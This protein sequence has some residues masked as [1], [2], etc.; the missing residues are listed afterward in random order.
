MNLAG[1]G[2]YYQAD[3]T[4]IDLF[5]NVVVR[6]T[7]RIPNRDNLDSI[8]ITLR[9]SDGVDND[10]DKVSVEF[11]RTY[12]NIEKERQTRSTAAQQNISPT[13]SPSPAK[14]QGQQYGQVLHSLETSCDYTFSKTEQIFMAGLAQSLLHGCG[15]PQDQESRRTLQTF[16]TSSLI[17]AAIGGTDYSNP[18]IGKSVPNSMASHIAYAAGTKAY[19]QIGCSQ[20]GKL[21]S[22]GM[23]KYLKK[24]TSKESGGMYFVDGC[25]HHYGGQWLK[26][27]CQC[28][29]DVG[30]AIFPN[31]HKSEF[32]PGKIRAIIKGNPLL[33][34][35]M[36][37]QCGVMD[38]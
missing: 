3:I 34:I 35:Q 15:Y 21:I 18:D 32:D 10:M 20:A 4:G 30:R 25:V 2:T 36:I 13:C 16:L 27:K 12:D 37:G 7:G 8:D 26:S 17:V 28:V 6:Y 14:Y 38:Y 5:K 11:L 33:S 23:V 24:S 1:K 19:E 22:Q 29:A 31:I 9:K